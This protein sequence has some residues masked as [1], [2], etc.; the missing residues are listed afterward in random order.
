[1]LAGLWLLSAAAGAYEIVPA[2]VAP[3]VRADLGIGA[4]AA[5][6]LVSVMFAVAV[7]TSIPLGVGV[8]RLD[9]RRVMVVAAIALVAAGG[10]GW[11]AA[12]RGDYA[13]LLA[14][15]VL[16]ALAFV[17]IWNAGAA[18]VGRAFDPD[19]AG[20]AIAAFTT[21]GPAGFGLGGLTGPLVA[22]ALGWEW[23]LVVYGSLAVVGIAVYLPASAG[24][25]L[26]AADAT[27]PGVAEFKQVLADR[28]V[29]HV[30]G[31]AFLAY[32]I[33]LFVN[34]W[35]PTY[36]TDGLGVSLAASGA[37]TGLFA[38]VGVLSR[39]SGG[40]LSDRLF[41][42]RRRPVVVISFAASVPLVAGLGVVEYVPALLVVLLAAGFF[43]Q[44]TLGLALS[45][46]RELV[47]PPVETTAIAVA[48]A[49]S[50]SGAFLSPI[51]AAAVYERTGSYG[52]T[53]VLAVAATV[54]G[55]GLAWFAPEAE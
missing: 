6:A 2:S 3:L 35:M 55:V 27:A 34:S 44:F 19:V 32:A 4:T 36:L 51:V 1:M 47:T 26:R 25:S 38:G 31:I 15:R 48:T 16:G 41:G 37:L 20:T 18:A 46:A 11:W 42:T 39:I 8:D 28:R 54:L 13:S 49:L 52:A 12:R 22:A 33:Y 43:V 29:W 14:S 45:Y 17:T 10:W 7:V 21:S 5:S 24:A 53:F 30:S 50:L 40:A 9:T 23:V